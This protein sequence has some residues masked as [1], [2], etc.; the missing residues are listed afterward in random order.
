MF[1]WRKNIRERKE[2]RENEKEERNFSYLIARIKMRKKKNM[3]EIIDGSHDFPLSKARGRLE[4]DSPLH[5]VDT[6]AYP[7]S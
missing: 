4:S 1:G 7:K 2:R 3:I 6:A 5:I